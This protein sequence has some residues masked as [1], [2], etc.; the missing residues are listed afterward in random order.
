[1]KAVQIHRYGGPEELIYEDAQNPQIREDDVLVRIKATSINPID[2]KVRQGIHKDPQRQFPLILGWD[3]SG[4][5]EK[6][7]A[8]AVGFKINDE[9]YG[10][11]DTSRNGTYAE[12]VAVRASEIALKPRSLDHN[13]AAAIPLA[14]LTAWQGIFDHGQLQPLQRILI[15]GAS[16]GVGTMAVQL[17]KWKGA[18]VIGTASQKN[19]DFLRE[20]G[21]D[22]VIDYE[23]EHFEDK[24]HDIDLVFDT[25]G[26]DVQMNSLKVLKPGGILVST[27]GIKDEAAVKAKGVKGIAYMAKSLPDQLRQMA[28]LIDAGKLKPIISRTLPLKEAAQGQRESEQGHTRGKIVLTV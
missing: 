26:G 1:M 8:M 7:G 20:L 17:A 12:Y 27:V 9:V 28:A 25:I 2:W 18:Y 5:I 22:E 16:G 14:G 19:A 3:V 13:Q 6:I 4:V 10:R 15:H 11:P 21:A 24:L 23:S